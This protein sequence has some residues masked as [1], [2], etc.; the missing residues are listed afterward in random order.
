MDEAWD[1]AATVQAWLGMRHPI[2]ISGVEPPG[3]SAPFWLLFRNELVYGLL[4]S[5]YENIPCFSSAH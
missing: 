2:A 5:I 3:F 1:G 4:R